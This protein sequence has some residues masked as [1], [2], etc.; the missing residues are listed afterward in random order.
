MRV[1]VNDSG[2]DVEWP[3]VA[4]ADIT[5]EKPDERVEPVGDAT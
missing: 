4:E 1:I 3:V 2:I 5:A